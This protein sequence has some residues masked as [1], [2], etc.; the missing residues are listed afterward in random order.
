ML[1]IDG[2]GL[3][4]RGGF[5]FDD[6]VRLDVDRDGQTHADHEMV[7]DHHDSNPF[8]GT[9]CHPCLPVKAAG[10]SSS[11]SAAVSAAE[12]SRSATSTMISVPWPGTLLRVS[13]PP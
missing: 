9:G 2:N 11:G 4:A 5:H 10:I 8:F 12:A 3:F 7:I 6:H 1:P 13:A